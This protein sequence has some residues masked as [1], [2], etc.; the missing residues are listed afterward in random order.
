VSSVR[1][2]ALSHRNK[3]RYHYRIHCG[4]FGNAPPAISQWGTSSRSDSP[5]CHV[6]NLPIEMQPKSKSSPPPTFFMFFDVNT[7]PRRNR[8]S[9][10]KEREILN[11]FIVLGILTFH[12]F[13][14]L[15]FFI[16][17]SVFSFRRRWFNFKGYLLRK[18]Y[19]NMSYYK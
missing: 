1:P 12:L 11:E 18:Q 16:E 15:Y 6:P 19:I 14:F 9:E 17:R 10:G 8:L 4:V 13:S 7:G 3:S 5:T 2:Q